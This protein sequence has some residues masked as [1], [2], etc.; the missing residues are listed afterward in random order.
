MSQIFTDIEGNKYKILQPSNPCDMIYD[1][2][3]DNP[4]V[5]EKYQTGRMALPHLGLSCMADISIATT[6]GVDQLLKSQVHCVTEK[7]I[8]PV[9]DH[10]AFFRED[11]TVYPEED[12]E[13][14]KTK[15]MQKV[16]KVVKP[17][18]V[19][20]Q[21]PATSFEFEF[22]IESPFA[23]KVS[24]AG[25]FNGWNKDALHLEKQGNTWRKKATL[26]IDASKSSYQFKFVING[27]DWVVNDRLPV[28]YDEHH[29]K[30]NKVDIPRGGSAGPSF[31]LGVPT[32]Q[33]AA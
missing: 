19:V 21:P 5:L 4:S 8:Y 25:A 11:T 12:D 6:W 27:S 28:A 13:P 26:P 16:E 2:T 18:P 23:S 3:H 1:V 32:I 14:K 29:N 15:P 22:W 17:P 20:H 24:V 9:A 30:N 10:G 7:C 33:P 31:S